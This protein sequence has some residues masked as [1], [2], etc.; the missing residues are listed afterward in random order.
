AF[1][2]E[3]PVQTESLVE[4]TFFQPLEKWSDIAMSMG[5]ALQAP[6]TFSGFQKFCKIIVEEFSAN[7][8]ICHLAKRALVHRKFPEIAQKEAE[9]MQ[10]FLTNAQSFAQTLHALKVLKKETRKLE[11]F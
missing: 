11:L 8:F 3:L 1:L 9:E 4:E 6:E 2:H 5:K 7:S 10:A